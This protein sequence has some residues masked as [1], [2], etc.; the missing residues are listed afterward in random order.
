MAY[1]KE[2]KAIS[3]AITILYVEDDDT[4]RKSVAEYLKLIFP[5]VDTAADGIEGFDAFKSNLYDI[6][7][8]DIQ[9]PRM[10]GIQMI[11]MIKET[12]PDQEIVIATAFS[13]VSYLME[14]IAL[15]VS[16]YLIKP[17]NYDFI[18]KTLYKIVEKIV[19][20]REN[21]MYQTNLKEMVEERTKKNLALEQEK[22]DNYEMTLLSLVEIVEQRDTY[23]GGHSQRVANYC[24][25]IAK[26]MGYSEE[27]C[28]LIYR[29]GI[30]HDIGKIATPDAV[31]LKPG[32]LDDLESRLIREHVTTGSSML[33][34]I[35]M[36][37]ELSKI[38]AAHHERYDGMGYPNG[39]KGDEILPLSQIMIVADAFDAITT[40]RIYK[41]RKN[42]ADAIYEIKELSGIQFHPEVV[43]AAVSVL[44]TT[45]IDINISQLPS[46]EMEKKRFA[47]FFEDS[48]TKVYNQNYLDLVLI[49]NQNNLDTKYLT[50]IFIHN[51]SAYNNTHG[52]DKGDIFLK[53]F[54]DLIHTRLPNDLIFR[55]HGDD[56]VILSDSPTTIDLTLFDTLLSE[57][58]N[59]VKLEYQYYNTNDYSLNSLTELEA[60][61]T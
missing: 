2:L 13:E 5:V 58:N 55:L 19:K 15:G 14:A 26:K 12:T 23:T 46:T 61:L 20:Y 47:F 50:I 28:N 24:Q 1:L 6:V 25:L 35:P 22:I 38:V 8:T 44:D 45:V 56:F 7:I 36:Y 33:K 18:N 60:Y 49:H 40:N 41:P 30:L 34:K 9:M 59:I 16:G 57:A 39:L 32:K 31:L 3:S 4:L 37:L 17:I 48:M 21:E 43:D 27:E 11:K 42:V 10:N 51:F 54:V 52:W 29:A 53:S